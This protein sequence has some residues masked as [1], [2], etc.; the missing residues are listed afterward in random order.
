MELHRHLSFSACAALQRRKGPCL[1]IYHKE[2]VM[3]HP[4]KCFQQQSSGHQT[5]DCQSNRSKLQRCHALAHN[6]NIWCNLQSQQLP[7]NGLLHPCLDGLF[8]SLCFPCK[9]IQLVQ[10]IAVCKLQLE[11]ELTCGMRLL[12]WLHNS[13]GTFQSR[14]GHQH[15]PLPRLCDVP[16]G[17]FQGC[18]KVDN[19]R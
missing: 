18:C 8:D 10:L 6:K 19:H 7:S 1:C 4:S 3:K 14:A 5:S 11:T 16:A 12:P 9:T 2:Y 13:S 17:T 15:F